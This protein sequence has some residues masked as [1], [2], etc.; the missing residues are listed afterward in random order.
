MD[1]IA[2]VQL[3]ALY[4]AGC[5]LQEFVEDFLD[6]CHQVCWD[7]NRLKMH[8][9]SGSDDELLQIMLV[10][11]DNCSLFENIDYA[12][13][14]TGSPLIVEE[15]A[16]PEPDALVSTLPAQNPPVGHME[17]TPEPGPVPTP[18]TDEE[19]EPTADRESQLL[20]TRVFM[21]ELTPS[22][23]PVSICLR[24]HQSCPSLIVL[25]HHLSYLS[26]SLLPDQVFLTCTLHLNQPFPQLCLLWLPPSP[27]LYH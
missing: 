23:E 5:P 22:L 14:L 7:E 18:I 11:N 26:P 19:P 3:L 1:Y 17:Q 6:L 10:G 8:F 2:E 13:C 20:P 15:K 9:W 21:L 12:L 16:H 4:Q 24:R 27:Q 25:C